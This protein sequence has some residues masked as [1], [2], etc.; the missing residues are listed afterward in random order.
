MV[1][2]F[3]T[4]HKL[5][6]IGS[7][8]CTLNSST[9]HFIIIAVI[10][11][12]LWKLAFV[13]STKLIYVAQTFISFCSLFSSYNPNLLMSTAYYRTDLFPRRLE[14]VGNWFSSFNSMVL[15]RLTSLFCLY[16]Y[17]WQTSLAQS[18]KQYILTIL[19][20]LAKERRRLKLKWPWMKQLRINR[21]GYYQT[22]GTKIAILK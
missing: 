16:R 9:F 7:R 11:S 17:R 14:Q 19:T 20:E 8:F 12:F 6:I 10:S 21:E 2:G 3:I 22:L 15:C 18:W 13:I 5:D 1:N 4:W